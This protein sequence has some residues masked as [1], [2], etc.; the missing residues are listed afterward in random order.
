MRH[1]MGQDW[2]GRRKQNPDNAPKVTAKMVNKFAKLHGFEIFRATQLPSGRLFEG[3]HASTWW[4]V[5]DG[6]NYSM[7]ET[8][9][10]ALESMK[11]RV[12][13]K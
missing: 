11:R 9:Y 2:G 3:S 5:V 10:I 4:I 13:A 6:T 1:T 7:G 12:G 8:N